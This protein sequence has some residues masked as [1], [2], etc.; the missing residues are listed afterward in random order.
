MI[1]TELLKSER[2]RICRTNMVYLIGVD[3]AVQH[4]TGYTHTKNFIKYL[5]HKVLELKPVII[6]EEFSTDCPT[7]TGKK[8]TT[9]QTVAL[10]NGIKHLFCDPTKAQRK[11]IGWNSTADDRIREEFWLGKIKPF[12]RGSIIFVC[13]LKHL[14]TF[15]KLLIENS[16]EC[17][18]TKRKFDLSVVEC[19]E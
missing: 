16:I 10:K 14:P 17:E 8:V 1:V 5:E 6:G 2:L 9:T 11:E 12:L 19:L 15:S 7:I 3:H 4:D 18:V 13:G